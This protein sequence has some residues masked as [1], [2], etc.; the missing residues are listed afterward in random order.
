MISKRRR[1]LIFITVSVFVLAFTTVVF[2]PLVKTILFAASTTQNAKVDYIE[3]ITMISDTEGWAVGSSLKGNSYECLMLHYN[4]GK[5]QRDKCDFNTGLNAVSMVSVREGWAVG[6]NGYILHYNGVDWSSVEG[7]ISGVE[8]HSVYASSPHDVWA[9]GDSGTIL[10]YVE[11]KW[12]KLIIPYKEN[13][14]GLHFTSPTEGWAVGGSSGSIK[15]SLILHF[16]DG[17]WMRQQSPTDTRLSSIFMNTPS[18]GWA[19]G[20]QADKESSG[21]IVHYSNNKWN[22]VDQQNLLP[23][24]SVHMKALD[25]G[26]A[27][28]GG[29]FLDSGNPNPVYKSAVFHY[30]LGH[31]TRSYSLTGKATDIFMTSVEEGW[32]VG[33]NTIQKFAEGRW[34]KYEY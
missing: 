19:V 33:W 21:V 16:K 17:V 15:S 1:D 4:S 22:I 27:V 2:Y 3:D 31:W 13:I 24:N 32:L 18:E 5:W 23:L 12:I 29:L 20:G 30:A 14:Y 26:W 10:H 8:L 28:G 34:T 6:S 7:G 25:D 9:V 11:G